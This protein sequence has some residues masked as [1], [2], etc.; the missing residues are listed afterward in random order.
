MPLTSSGAAFASRAIV[1]VATPV[2]DEAN[3]HIGVGNGTGAFDATQTDLAGT[4]FVRKGMEAGY[5]KTMGDSI[6]AFRATF[7][8]NEANFPWEEWGVF[9]AAEQGVMLNREVEYNG[10]KLEGQLWILQVE[11]DVQVGS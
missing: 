1:G 5:P 10:T 11:L 3:S 7:E 8:A 2:F 6:I 9:N 4:S